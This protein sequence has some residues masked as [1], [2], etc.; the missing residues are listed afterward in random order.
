MHQASRGLP[1]LVLEAQR[2]RQNG[3]GRPELLCAVLPGRA[4]GRYAGQLQ[5]G[6]CAGEEEES[7]MKRPA[8]QPG[9]AARES[10]GQGCCLLRALCVGHGCQS[11]LC[12]PGPGEH[13]QA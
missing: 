2:T 9:W 13:V 1:E 5:T 7:L 4:G 10:P 3:P 11:I 12:P 6:R 8:G